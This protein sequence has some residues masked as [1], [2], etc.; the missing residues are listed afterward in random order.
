MFYRI[1]SRIS[2]KRVLALFVAANTVY[3]TMLIY[4]IPMLMQYSSGL[5]IF[6]MSPLGYSYKEAMVLLTSLGDEGRN[7]YVSIQLILDL[8]YPI[9]FALCYFALLQWLIIVG[10]LSNR[11]WLYISII[12][13]FACV[14]DY[15]ENICIWLMI[16]GYPTIAEDL[17]VVSSI[18]TQAKS[19]STM[20]YFIALISA[21]VLLITR[22]V[23]RRV[24]VKVR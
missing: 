21:L 22:W 7:A 16:Q 24:V 4:S 5:P 12:P 14:F 10:E 20:I 2:G 11:L 1:Q 3:F 15:A 18:F 9:L 23:L 8:F 19:I 6:D 17:V 13:I